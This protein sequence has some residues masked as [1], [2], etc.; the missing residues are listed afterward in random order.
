MVRYSLYPMYS[1]KSVAHGFQ[2][3]TTA[4]GKAAEML[5]HDTYGRFIVRDFQGESRMI[6]VRDAS[7]RIVGY[8]EMVEGYSLRW[9]ADGKM[10]FMSYY[11]GINGIAKE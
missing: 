11:G 2:S 7:K 9:H 3:I 5:Y 10:Y 4:R 6:A 8:V 1:D